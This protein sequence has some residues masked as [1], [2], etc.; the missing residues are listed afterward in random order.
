MNVDRH[1]PPRAFSAGAV[2]LHHCADIELEPDELVTFTTASGT[3]FDVTRKGWG[4][5]A[6]PSLNG[7]L[8]E[9]G[10]RSALVVNP[11][12]RLYVL[13]VEAGHED[14]FTAYLAR[15]SMRVVAWLDSDDAAAEAVRRLEAP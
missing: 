12:G 6:T 13:L 5:Y 11:A 14:E 1:D 15:E 7:R 8:V 9:H 3:A 10:L 4:Y 2:Q